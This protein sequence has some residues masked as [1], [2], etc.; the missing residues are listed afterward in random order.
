[1]AMG[2]PGQP[3]VLPDLTIVRGGE[4]IR[5]EG[6]ERDALCPPGSAHEFAMIGIL[7]HQHSLDDLFGEIIDR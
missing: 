6:R 7:V 2:S 3:F 5:L 1:M 4:P